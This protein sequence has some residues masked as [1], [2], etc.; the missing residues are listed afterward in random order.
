[1][2]LCSNY[3][4]S[5]SAETLQTPTFW[6]VGLA[7]APCLHPAVLLVLLTGAPHRVAPA[8]GERRHGESSIAQ[9]SKTGLKLAF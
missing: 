5:N 2:T 4:V 6:S 1:M 8:G 3:Y 9:E 7:A